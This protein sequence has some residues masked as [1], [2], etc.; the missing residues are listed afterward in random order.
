MSTVR[1]ALILAATALAGATVGAL[2]VLTFRPDVALLLAASTWYGAAWL[3]RR[4]YGIA[5]TA[6]ALIV[7][8]HYTRNGD[9]K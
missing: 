2:A 6:L 5:L 1:A 8:H 9:P 4:R 3:W 7:W